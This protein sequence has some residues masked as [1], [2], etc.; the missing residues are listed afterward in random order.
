MCCRA[1]NLD[2]VII[3][4]LCTA[5]VGISVTLIIVTEFSIYII[6]SKNMGRI[7]VQMVALEYT[8]L[9]YHLPLDKS[10]EIKFG[11]CI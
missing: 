11:R 1:N 5:K 6:Y 2:I 3:A 8:L 9:I 4:K 10:N 7:L